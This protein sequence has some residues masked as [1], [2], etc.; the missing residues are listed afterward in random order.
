[1]GAWGPGLYSDDTT[2]EIRDQYVSLLEEGKSGTMAAEEIVAQYKDV[3]DNPEV[4]CLVFLAL[5]DTQWKY[6]HLNDQIKSR[7]I[8]IID[9]GGDV[10]IWPKDSPRDVKAREKVLSSLRKKLLSPQPVARILKPKRKRAPRMLFDGPVGSIFSVDLPTGYL[11]LLKVVGFH[12]SETMIDPVF[13]LIRWQGRELPSQAQIE[14]IAAHTVPLNDDAYFS[15]FHSDKRNNPVSLLNS[16]GLLVQQKELEDTTIY[17][18]LSIEFLAKLIQE[19]LSN[20]R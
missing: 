6:G 15:V 4:E 9:R 20:W 14:E 2:C 13:Q 16:T 7:A 8:G 3:L 12:H 18:G 17:R 10:D 5:A 1:M 11:A 19:A